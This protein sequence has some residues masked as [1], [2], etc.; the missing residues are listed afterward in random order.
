MGCKRSREQSDSPPSS[1]S[2]PPN[3]TTTIGV[4]EQ[5]S[6]YAHLDTS[7]PSPTDSISCALPPH[8]PAMT[9]STYDAY[10]VH[11]QQTHAN[12]CADCGRN[13]PTEHFLGLHIAESHD[14]LNQARKARGEKIVSYH[15][16]VHHHSPLYQKMSV[17]FGVA[18]WLMIG[19]LEVCM[20]RRGL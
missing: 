19:F 12:R 20:F 1:P 17:T 14:P 18:L 9:F 2:L 5:P 3:Q 11:Y 4:A 15:P 16:Y 13:F 7:T 6:K 8:G 10:E